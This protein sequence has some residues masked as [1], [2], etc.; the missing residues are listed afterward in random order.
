MPWV[1]DGVNSDESGALRSV[2]NV[3][4]R[5][6]E[7]AGTL[8]GLSWFVDDVTPDE[9]RGLGTL[10]RIANLD[11]ARMMVSL[12]WFV[13]DLTSD[14]STALYELRNIAS[15]N[16][17]LAKM[18]ARLPSFIDGIT[19]YESDVLGDLSNN[20]AIL[21]G[22]G[23]RMITSLPSFTG[24]F[25]DLLYTLVFLQNIGAK[26]TDTLDQL[27]S[28]P[29]FADGLD[30]E[31]NALIATLGGVLD[32]S[33][34]LY[35]DLLHSHFIQTRK[36]SLPLDGEV[37]IYVIEKDPPSIQ[38]EN[39]LTIIGD[40]AR[41]SEGF[42][43]VPF[44][45]SDIILLIAGHE[46]GLGATH[47]E[48]FITSPRVSWDITVDVVVHETAHYY[49]NYFPFDAS[50]LVEGGAEFI[51]AYANDQAGVQNIGDR[52]IEVSEAVLQGCTYDSVENIRHNEYLVELS[53]GTP[54]WPGACAYDMGEQFLIN[55]FET[56]GEDAMS[57]ALRE[58]YL[59][60]YDSGQAADEEAIYNAFLKHTSDD[61]KEDLRDLYRKLHGGAFVFSEGA[62]DD[63]HGDE[64]GLATEIA[65]GEAVMGELD[66]MFDFDYFTF[67]AEED[68]KYSITV[69]HESLG[70]SSV[71][72]YDPD[73]QTQG[74]W[75][76][77]TREPSG[78]RMQWLA[79]SSD[80]YYFVVQNFGGKTG[81]YTLT[82]TPFSPIED[83]HGDDIA[84][85]TSISLGEVVQGAIDD[86][87]DY[88]YFQFQ[89]VEGKR[90][91][92]V[93]EPSTL[94]YHHLH[95]FAAEGVP[96]HFDYGFNYEFEHQ[97]LDNPVWGNE[98]V[99][100]EFT[101]PTSGPFYLAIDGADGSVGSYTITVT[102]VDDAGE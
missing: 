52:R 5:D 25:T 29:W 38:D 96:H 81:G 56:I 63:D 90:Y 49:F 100:G 8:A 17:E 26:S 53:R 79:P 30:Q 66:Y 59:Q 62:F 34:N 68:Q 84:S 41:I 32:E 89:S 98:T 71:T 10:A 19:R 51:V 61:K 4:R 82:I 37:N 6:L 47:R 57:A 1:A 58:L 86:D 23:T 28:Q 39:I 20:S 43:Q 69:N 42:M 65:V 15:D 70:A 80:E 50:W 83:D 31:E 9:H 88:D 92:V 73:G 12:P 45:T 46:Y 64:A 75:K 102:P 94:D 76:S 36:V 18:I 55:I 11:L 72:L 78:P 16:L 60:S 77:L 35:S 97:P 27:A 87:F 93:I 54:G 13:D 67:Q 14:E 22:E 44:P 85:A 74:R 101:A 33:P 3:A 48:T 24:D 91:R 95:L 7:L 2:G 40:A 21:P 99:I